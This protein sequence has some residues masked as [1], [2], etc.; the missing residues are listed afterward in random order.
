MYTK[1]WKFPTFTLKFIFFFNTDA[2]FLENESDFRAYFFEE[3]NNLIRFH[4]K[5]PLVAERTCPPTKN[6]SVDHT[7]TLKTW[8]NMVS[9]KYSWTFMIQCIRVL[10]DRG[11]FK[12][13][14]RLQIFKITNSVHI[15][16]MISLTINN[17]FINLWNLYMNIGLVITPNWIGRSISKVNHPL[18]WRFFG[19]GKSHWIISSALAAN[20]FMTPWTVVDSS[21][22][23][24]LVVDWKFTLADVCTVDF[25]LTLKTLG[26]IDF[27]GICANVNMYVKILFD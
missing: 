19:W 10:R 8:L 2:F 12:S 22:L 20:A 14:N 26:S 16:A 25:F 24:N 4:S 21:F 9:S 15:D 7:N 23:S 17:V 13:V 18:D 1:T 3:R 6:A 5:G 27:G 11:D